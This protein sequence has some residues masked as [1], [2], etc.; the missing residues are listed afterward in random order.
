MNAFGACRQRGLSLIELL[1]AMVLGLLVSTGAVSIFIQMSAHNRVQRQ[2]ARL[3]EE[4]RFAIGRLN[5]DIALANGQYCNNTGG[6][7]KQQANGIYLDALRSPQVYATGLADAME[8]S[9]LTT[10]MGSAPYPPAPGTPYPLPSFLAMRGYDCGMSMCTPVDPNAAGASAIPQMGTTIDSRVRGA[11]VL[12]MRYIDASSGWA[13]GSGTSIHIDPAFPGE[14]KNITLS[15]GDNEPPRSDFSPT[16]L[17]ML[18]DCAGAQIFSVNV[19]GNTLTP[20]GYNLAAPTAYEQAVAARLFDFNRDYRTV[21]YYL[22][23]VS[24][25]NDGHTGALIRQTNGNDGNKGGTREELVR[26]VERL[27]FRYAVEDADG[28]VSYLTAA[29]V[30]AGVSCPPAPPNAPNALEVGCMWRAVKGVHASMLLSGHLALHTLKDD[31]LSYLYEPD[32]NDSAPPSAHPIKP[33]DQGFETKLIRR[34]F[35]TLVSVRNFNP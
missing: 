18:A 26:G 1:V 30:D 8:S 21:T 15:P 9:D 5:Q 4:G 35:N 27:D 3:Q 31:E 29:E 6:S 16:H 13:I 20:D 17:A 33:S 11:D 2:L 7:A 22:A 12:T 19:S 24:N 10:R 14:L 25:G 23:V 28:N 34:E 32:S